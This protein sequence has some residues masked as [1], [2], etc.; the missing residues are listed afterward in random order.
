MV[1]IRS[2]IETA[3][4][5]V[6]LCSDPDGLANFYA[7]TLSSTK[8]ISGA[9]KVFPGLGRIYG[10]LSNEFVHIGEFHAAFDFMG[11]YAKDDEDLK[12]ILTNMK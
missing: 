7:G 2:I 3:A 10:M 4:G 5:V 6:R 1:L 12:V 8:A 11:D 9:S